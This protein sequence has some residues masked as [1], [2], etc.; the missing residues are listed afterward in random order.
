MGSTVCIHVNGIYQIR[1]HRCVMNIICD[2]GKQMSA[3]NII[4]R[5]VLWLLL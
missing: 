5:K 1:G 4:I 2:Y 3:M